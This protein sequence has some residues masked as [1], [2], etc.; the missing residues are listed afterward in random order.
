MELGEKTRQN[1]SNGLKC[2]QAPRYCLIRRVVK[3]NPQSKK[4]AQGLKKLKPPLEECR[5]LILLAALDIGRRLGLRACLSWIT[6]RIRA[7]GIS[8]AFAGADGRAAAAAG[9][10]PFRFSAD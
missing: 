7:G 3:G 2:A 6:R 1:G 9:Q 5:D 10:H 8:R 4:Q